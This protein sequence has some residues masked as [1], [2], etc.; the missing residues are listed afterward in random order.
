MKNGFPKQKQQKV[1][2]IK[3][4]R[5]C[6]KA[7][8][9]Y[10]RSGFFFATSNR[11]GSDCLLTA[12]FTNPCI[13]IPHPAQQVDHIVAACVHSGLRNLGQSWRTCA[14][15]PLWS[16]ASAFCA[17]T[18]TSSETSDELVE[19]RWPLRSCQ[20]SDS[21]VAARRQESLASTTDP[22][23]ADRRVSHSKLRSRRISE[24]AAG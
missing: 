21:L 16:W 10:R 9:H 23:E 3:P 5:N 19:R 14:P 24:G 11:I 7:Q 6:Y 17:A 22:M 20:G 4:D 15:R 18:V 1:E 12:I 2:A 13:M 8:G